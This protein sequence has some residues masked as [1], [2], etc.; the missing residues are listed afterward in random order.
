MPRKK[1]REKSE[2][3]EG[4]L[5]ISFLILK[6]MK[7]QC[8]RNIVQENQILTKFKKHCPRNKETMFKKQNEVLEGD[9]LL[10]KSMKKQSSRN[11]ETCSRNKMKMTTF[12]LWRKK[13]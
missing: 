8:S 9:C 1:K 11:K 5:T 12:T 13:N 2:V 4:D 6:A 7:K 3:L 10:L